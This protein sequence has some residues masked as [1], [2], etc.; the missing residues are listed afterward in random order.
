LETCALAAV[1]EATTSMMT[2][3]TL[4]NGRM[5]NP[6]IAV[7]KHQYGALRGINPSPMACFS[8]ASVAIPQFH[9]TYRNFDQ[10][11]VRSLSDLNVTAYGDRT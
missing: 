4:V 9:S 8:G 2:T 11:A 1:A 10:Q 6:S 7:P 5:T 3:R